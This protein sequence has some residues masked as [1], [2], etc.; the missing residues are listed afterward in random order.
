MS[1]RSDSIRNKTTEL[2]GYS[3][4]E[5]AEIVFDLEEAKEELEQ[6]VSDLE[7]ERDDLAAQ[8]EH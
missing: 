8:V 4:Q 7:K 5:I 6:Q 2:T 1:W 3:L